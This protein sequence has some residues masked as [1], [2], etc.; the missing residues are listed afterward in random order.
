MKKYLFIFSALLLMV[1]SM[2]S[3]IDSKL[4]REIALADV[5]CPIS[6]GVAGEL[7]NM[8]YE[9]GNVIF[10]YEI[11]DDLIDV[12]VFGSNPG[13]MR[14]NVMMTLGNMNGKA[15]DI[16][17]LLVDEEA[18]LTMIYKGRSRGEEASITLSTDDIREICKGSTKADPLTILQGELD[19]TNAQYPQPMG[20]GIVMMKVEIEGDY[21]VYVASV[22]ENN[23]SVADLKANAAGVKQNVMQVINQGDIAMNQFK[24][25]CKNAHKGLSYKYVGDTSGEVCQIFIETSEM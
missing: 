17:Q 24:N 1:M 16:L 15:K 2:T 22:D 13:M 9:D 18:S 19:I 25:M 4:K 5:Q 11:N 23:I 3:C 6:L 7:S 20:N 10:R 14:Q 12:K 8:E 21:V